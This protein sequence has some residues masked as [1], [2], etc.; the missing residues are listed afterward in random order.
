[1]LWEEA[2]ERIYEA[3]KFKEHPYLASVAVTIQLHLN[4]NFPGGF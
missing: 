3:P 1:M 4:F 2:Y